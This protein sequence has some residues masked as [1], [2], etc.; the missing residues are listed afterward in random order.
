MASFRKLG[1]QAANYPGRKRN[2][3]DYIKDKALGI[4]F[5]NGYA[6]QSLDN[7]ITAHLDSDFPTG[8]EHGD[9][10]ALSERLQKAEFLLLKTQE[11][12]RMDKDPWCQTDE[13]LADDSYDWNEDQ[14]E[15]IDLDN[16]EL[17]NEYLDN[18]DFE[19]GV[20]DD[21]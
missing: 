8:C 14:L 2:P 12:L 5:K 7:V 17:L 3:M 21:D 20:I 10:L 6:A 18:G 1:R 16:D 19:D 11:Y 9:T 4:A 13:F 15:Y